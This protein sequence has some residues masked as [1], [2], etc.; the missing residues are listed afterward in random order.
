MFRR[1]GLLLLVVLLS[2]SVV[3]AQEVI[4]I[5]YAGWA[6]ASHNQPQEVRITAFE[7]A[8][9]HIKVN[10]L[11]IPHEEY[12]D[13]LTAMAVAGELPDVF[14]INHLPVYI[15]NGWI[16]D[17]TDFV[18]NDPTFD[19]DMFFGNILEAGKARGRYFGLPF[20]LQAAYFMV[21]LETLDYFGLRMPDPDW[22]HEDLWNICMRMNR[23]AQ[24]YF[25][26]EDPWVLWAHM[27]PAFSDKVTWDAL[28]LDGSGFL[29]DDPQVIEGF[30]WALEFERRNSA[31]S[32]GLGENPTPTPWSHPRFVEAYGNASPW[33][34]S[35]A[36][37][38]VS[39]SWML[40][41]F[42]ENATVPYDVIPYPRG[43]VRQVTPLIVDTMGI[44]P[45]S[46]NKEAAYAFLRW[47]S[48]D[49]QGWLDRMDVERPAP[50]S[51][52]TINAPEVWEKYLSLEFIPPGM[53]HVVAT[54]DNGLFD[55]NRTTPGIPEVWSVVGPARDQIRMGL[56][57]YDDLFPIIVK[58]QTDAIFRDARRQHEAAL[59]RILGP[60]K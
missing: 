43:P 46:E 48:Y 31:V 37:F 55:P 4:E 12:D 52:P 17:I 15:R 3:S 6:D 23:P 26:M 54:L 42:Y 50:F 14:W 40:T 53:K 21:N 25:G 34:Q 32:L 11:F 13:R 24:N 22:T 45:V 8:H 44:S 30:K 16:A 20:Q 5:T 18:E 35:K 57:E 33:D 10:Y 1:I 9:P 49:L 56:A 38:H 28:A 27:V 51:L 2:S 19:P 47:M 39:H 7:A 41:W 29:L 58:E 36:A 59:D 60:V